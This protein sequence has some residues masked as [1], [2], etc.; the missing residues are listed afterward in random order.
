MIQLQAAMGLG[1]LL[2]DFAII[3]FTGVFPLIWVLTAIRTIRKEKKNGYPIDWRTYAYAI[4]KGFLYGFLT[5]LIIAVLIFM[6]LYY[7]VDL[8][9]S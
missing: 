1:I 6:W 3:L 9:I 4:M 8:S 5:L 2:Y 7:F